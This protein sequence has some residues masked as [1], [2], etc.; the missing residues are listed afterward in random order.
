MQVI[1]FNHVMLFGNATSFIVSGLCRKVLRSGKNKM[2]SLI[3]LH[4]YVWRSKMSKIKMS[5]N[6]FAQY[7]YRR[8]LRRHRQILISSPTIG[9]TLSKFRKMYD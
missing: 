2:K 6:L 1:G 4:V 7:S 5:S 9:M 8:F 3:L